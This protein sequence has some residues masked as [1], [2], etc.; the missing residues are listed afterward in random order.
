MERDFERQVLG[1]VMPTETVR[2]FTE[3]EKTMLEKANLLK[4]NVYEFQVGIAG[5]K[6]NVRTI[7]TVDFY[8]E[9]PNNFTDIKFSRLDYTYSDYNG[10]SDLV[11]NIEIVAIQKHLKN[12]VENYD[13][14]NLL[15]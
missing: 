11:M 6:P 3:V 7:F 13:V 15:K 9:L 14:K 4:I 2:G 8:S 1:L 12:A 5:P 10:E